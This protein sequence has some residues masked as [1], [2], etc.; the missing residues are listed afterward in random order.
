[1]YLNL[2]N[3]KPTQKDSIFVTPNKSGLHESEGMYQ[4]YLESSRLKFKKRKAKHSGSTQRSS[5]SEFNINFSEIV[6]T[7]QRLT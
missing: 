6:I 7:T 1:M 2:E 5:Y 4:P 3:C